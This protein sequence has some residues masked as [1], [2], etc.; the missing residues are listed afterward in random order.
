MFSGSTFGPAEGAQ[1]TTMTLRIDVLE[2]YLKKGKPPQSGYAGMVMSVE[3]YPVSDTETD[4][5]LTFDIPV[6][7]GS[8]GGMEI[9]Y[10]HPVTLELRAFNNKVLYVRVTNVSD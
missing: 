1:K 8:T 2:K 9:N 5:A 4:V 3:N 6:V 7:R 10:E